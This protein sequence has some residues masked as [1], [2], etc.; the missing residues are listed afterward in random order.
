MIAQ[1]NVRSGSTQTGA[2]P[3]THR[4]PSMAEAITA[5]AMAETPVYQ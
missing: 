1:A 3:L 4:L 2:S 5:N